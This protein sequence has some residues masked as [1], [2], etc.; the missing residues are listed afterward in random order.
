MS[1]THAAGRFGGWPRVLIAV[2]LAAAAAAASVF[3][4]R[5]GSGP[6]QHHVAFG[7]YSAPGAKGVQGAHDFDR[8]MHQH[9]T[10]VLDFPPGDDWSQIEGEPWLLRPHAEE[11]DQRLEYSLPV[12]PDLPGASLRACAEGDYDRHWATLARHLVQWHLTDTILRPGW[13]FNGDWY[14]WNAAGHVAEYISCFRH[15]VTSMRAV[16]GQRFAFDWNVNVGPGTL[17]PTT[18]W[19]GRDYVDYVGV[20]AYDISTSQYHVGDKPSATQHQQATTELLDG[21]WGLRFWARFAA[22]HGRP[23]AIPEWGLTWRV[24]GSGGGDNVT[25]LNAMLRFVD[26]PATHVAYACYFNSDDATSHHRLT[27]PTRFTRARA[28]YTEQV[29]QQTR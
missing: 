19:P 7:V 10:M 3:L 17:D 12:V 14:A 8:V 6:H 4:A 15:V 24:D 5:G 13:E 16:P 28:A 9:S 18:A 11:K 29:D 27:G 21:R 23:L 22:E 20:D 26:D 2:L 1:R 25:Y